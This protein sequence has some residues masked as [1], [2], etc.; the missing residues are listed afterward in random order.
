MGN[1]RHRGCSQMPDGSREDAV[2]ALRRLAS[3]EEPNENA[4]SVYY[5]RRSCID[6]GD[7][8]LPFM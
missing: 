8:F 7:C 6:R 1:R 3:P 4:S 2:V 5:W